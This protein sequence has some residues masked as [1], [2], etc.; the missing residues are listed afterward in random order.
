[1]ESLRRLY[2]DIFNRLLPDTT[3]DYQNAL[4]ELNETM[5]KR[6]QEDDGQRPRPFAADIK[7]F[8]GLPFFIPLGKE[9]EYDF[10]GVIECSCVRSPVD[11]YHRSYRNIIQTITSFNGLTE[12]SLVYQQYEGRRLY[13]TPN[14]YY[15]QHKLFGID[16]KKWIEGETRMMYE[17][18]L[19]GNNLMDLQRLEGIDT[20]IERVKAWTT[21]DYKN[22]KYKRS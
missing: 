10:T 3:K 7:Y 8:R 17:L 15:I 21:I 11:N 19:P 1:M 16:V 18:I 2:L 13:N 12:V 4:K 9:H 6:V 20:V 14:A 5:W 22:P